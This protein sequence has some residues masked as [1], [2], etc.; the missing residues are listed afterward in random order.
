MMAFSA[1]LLIVEDILLQIENNFIPSMLRLY[2]Y[3]VIIVLFVV[4]YSSNDLHSSFLPSFF[5]PHQIP[6]GFAQGEGLLCIGDIPNIKLVSNKENPGAHSQPYF[7]FNK[8]EL[9]S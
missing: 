2:S 9:S 3:S 1:S 7:V 5:K 6:L 8:E 4:E